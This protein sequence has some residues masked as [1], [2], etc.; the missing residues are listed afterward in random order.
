MW[1]AYVAIEPIVRRR[2]PDLLI[3]WTRLVSG[4][5]RDPLVGRDALAGILG[6]AVV[7]LALGGSQ[8]LPNWFDLPGMTPVPPQGPSSRVREPPRAVSSG[9]FGMRLSARSPS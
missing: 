4:R 1:L 9:C 6:G 5:F 8:A 7:W 3:S 2:W